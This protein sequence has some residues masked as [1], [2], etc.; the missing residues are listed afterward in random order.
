MITKNKPVFVVLLGKIEEYTLIRESP[1]TLLVRDERQRTSR[2][3]KNRTYSYSTA[4]RLYSTERCFKSKE[5]AFAFAIAQITGYEDWA[6][7][8]YERAT[9]K[10]E[11][12]FKEWT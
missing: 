1:K 10:K 9:R 12:L 3:W 11:E 2:V 7:N 6:M 5:D 4:G 8:H